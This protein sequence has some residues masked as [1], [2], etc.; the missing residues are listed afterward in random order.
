MDK[1]WYKLQGH[2]E[3]EWA[4]MRVAVASEP[5]PG[6]RF[7]VD[8]YHSCSD[9]N[10]TTTLATQFWSYLIL[11]DSHTTVY[12]QW[13]IIPVRCV[14]SHQAKVAFVLGASL[15]LPLARVPLLKL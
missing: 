6:Y 9:G 3:I 4:S 14:A 15:V 13:H 7:G 10:P 8:P 5:S 12:G 11:S 2:S 1:I